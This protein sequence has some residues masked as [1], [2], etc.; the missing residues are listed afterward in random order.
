MLD[1]VFESLEISDINN[2]VQKAEALT[3]AGTGT[4]Y[5]NTDK[6]YGVVH[7]E[8]T[9][10]G[11]FYGVSLDGN[12]N[13]TNGNVLTSTLEWTS[14]SGSSG[15]YAE[16]VFIR[17]RVDY[18]T[19]KSVWLSNNNYFNFQV[20]AYTYSNNNNVQNQK[21]LVRYFNT[22]GTQIGSDLTAE[23]TSGNYITTST[24]DP[25]QKVG[26]IE[27][28]LYYRGNNNTNIRNPEI[29]VT[30]EYNDTTA[31]TITLAESLGN[32]NNPLT[33]KNTLTIGDNSQLEKASLTYTPQ[34]SSSPTVSGQETSYSNTSSTMTLTQGNY[35]KYTVTVTDIFGLSTSK[36]FYYISKYN[37]ETTSTV[38]SL[39][40]MFGADDFNGSAEYSVPMAVSDVSVL[41]KVSDNK[42]YMYNTLSFT[43]N[44][45]SFGPVLSSDS[46]SGHA[47]VY[48]DI[49]LGEYVEKLVS[50]GVQIEVYFTGTSGSGISH[51]FGVF[52][53]ASSFTTTAA[54]SL[55]CMARWC[56]DYSSGN[57]S[58]WSDSNIESGVTAHYG[59]Q[60][61]SMT[62]GD[63]SVPR[64]DLYLSGRY[65]RIILGVYSSS[66]FRA[67]T[68]SSPTLK[69]KISDQVAPEIS[70]SAVSGYSEWTTSPSFT[71]DDNGTDGIYSYSYTFADFAGA[72]GQ[73]ASNTYSINDTWATS[74]P[75]SFPQMGIYT[76][77]A[78]DFLGNATEKTVKYWAPTLNLSIA[79][80]GAT[81]TTTGGTISTGSV[82]DATGTNYATSD[83]SNSYAI[84]DAMA[85][86]A[87]PNAGY[88]YA[89]L[90]KAS[91]TDSPSEIYGSTLNRSITAVASTSLESATDSNYSG[92]ISTSN[93]EFLYTIWLYK[94]P[95]ID[96]G[97]GKIN[98]VVNFKSINASFATSET[99]VLYNNISYPIT[100]N[101]TSYTH[102]DTSLEIYTAQGIYNGTLAGSNN[103]TT[104][105]PKNAGTYTYYGAITSGNIVLGKT[106]TQSLTIT[107]RPITLIAD[108]QTQVYGDTH[109]AL[110][111]TVSG[112]YAQNE[113]INILNF[114]I[115]KAEPEKY[116]AGS[117]A[118][119]ITAHND[120]YDI[121]I[122]NATYTISV[123]EMTLSADDKEI[124]YG[125]DEKT[126]TYS[127]ISGS[128]ASDADK[129]NIGVV[130][131]RE[132]GTV[133]NEYEITLSYA[134]DLDGNYRLTLSNE[135]KAK[136]TIK[137]R[138]ITFVAYDQTQVYGDTQKN[139]TY[140]VSGL[141]SG[142]YAPGED[143]NILNFSIAKS[144]PDIYDAGSYDIIITATNDN[145]DIT[146]TNAIYRIDQ[147]PILLTLTANS[148]S[149]T[150]GEPD[151]T[152]GYEVEYIGD[153]G[154]IAIV[155]ASDLTINVVRETGENVGEYT[156][157]IECV[158]KDNRE[159]Y[160][161]ETQDAKLI[162]NK[163]TLIGV[164]IG[165]NSPNTM[166]LPYTGTEFTLL[167]GYIGFAD[168]EDESVISGASSISVT[169]V[170]AGYTYPNAGKYTASYN[171]DTAT[172]SN[173]DI[174]AGNDVE[175]EITK[176]SLTIAYKEE[177]ITFGET[178]K[179]ELKYDGFVNGENTDVL[180]KP[181]S[182]SFENEKNSLGFV[183][184]GEYTITPSG[185]SA[186][187]YD[188]AYVS[189]TLTV[190]KKAITA[191]YTNVNTITYGDTIAVTMADITPSGLVS[192][193][194]KNSL[195]IASY[196][197][198]A[199]TNAGTHEIDSSNIT[200]TANNYTVTVSGSVTI[201]K[202]TL[203]IGVSFDKD[204][205]TYGE[206][207]VVSVVYKG[208]K[209]T[210]NE[211][212]V[213]G[214]NKPTA[215]LTLNEF[216]LVNAGTH[217]I[218]PSVVDGLELQ[219]YNYS[220]KSS[221][222]TI[223]KAT[224]TIT[225]LGEEVVYDGKPQKPS[226][227]KVEVVGFVA[228]D[229]INLG[230]FTFSHDGYST[231]NA[232]PSVNVI[233]TNDQVALLKNYSYTQH[234]GRFAVIPRPITFTA[235]DKTQVY[236]NDQTE[237]TYQVGGL[238]YAD[239]EDATTLGVTVQKADGND[240]G[241][242][243]ITV[244][245]TNSNYEVT[246]EKGTYTITA[247]PIE[248]SFSVNASK[249]YD[250]QTDVTDE[251]N[252][253][254]TNLVAGD[255][256]AL[257]GISAS[258]ENKDVGARTVTILDGFTLAGDDAANYTL[259]GGAINKD[260]LSITITKATLTVT[261]TFD[262]VSITEGDTVTAEQFEITYA[263]FVNGET[264]S[265]LTTK[266]SVDLIAVSNL[267]A[268]KPQIP[269]VGATATN[270]EF[271]YVV[272]TIEVK[273]ARTLIDASGLSFT[274]RDLT[275]NGLSQEITIVWEDMPSFVQVAYVYKN[276]LGSVVSEQKNVGT[277][278]VT[279]KFTVADA[280]YYM[281]PASYEAQMVIG[282]KAVSV[283][284]DS[285]NLSKIYDGNRDIT[286]AHEPE[287]VGLVDGE[288][289]SYNLAAT[290]DDANVGEAKKIT[291]VS[292]SATAG[293]NT[294]FENY[295]ITI[296]NAAT[297]SAD[298]TPKAVSVTFDS[299]NLS[300]VYDGNRDITLAREP[301]I[302]GLV[303]GES[304]SYN[305]AA[306]FDDAN[307]GEAKKI[308]LVSTSATADANTL[309]EN[310]DITITNADA[311]TA[312]VIARP[313]D[314]T[315]TVNTTKTYDGTTTLPE[316]HIAGVAFD[317][318]VDGEELTY[319]I[320]GEFAI[321]N[322]TLN[323]E[324]VTLTVTKAI[325]GTTASNYYF[326]D[327]GIDTCDGTITRKV[328]S[329]VLENQTSVYGEPVVVSND[330]W[331]EAVVDSIVEGDKL[332][333]T[334]SRDGTS[335][336][337]N[338]YPLRATY[339]N[340]NYSVTFTQA[341]Y[342][343]TQAET[344]VYFDKTN[345][346]FEYTGEKVAINSQNFYV[347][348]NRDN[349]TLGIVYPDMAKDT[350][351]GDVEIKNVG[352]YTLL[353]KVVNDT[354]DSIPDNFKETEAKLVVRVVK[355]K[356][357]FDFS[358]IAQTI[359]RY[360]GEEQHI[361][362]VTSTNTD[363]GAVINYSGNTFT[364]VPENGEIT[365]TV[366][367]SET[368]NYYAS[369]AT[370]TVFVLKANYDL[371]GYTFENETYDYDG[372]MHSVEVLGL[373]E[374]ISVT[375]T[376][377]DIVSSEPIEIKDAGIYIVYADYTYDE[378]NYEMP[379]LLKSAR[380]QINQISITV[381]VT[382]QEGYYGE[383]P[384]FD[385]TGVNVIAGNFIPGDPI[386]LELKLEPRDSYPI[387][388]YQ[389]V[390]NTTSSG[391]YNVTVAT[392]TY[393]I[394]PRPIVL[395][396]DNRGSEYGEEDAELAWSIDETSPYSIIEGD[397][398]NAA[399]M[400]AEGRTPGTYAISGTI[401]NP[402][403]AVTL[404]EGEYTITPRKI[405]I[406]LYNQEGTDPSHLNK[407]GY[408]V[409]GGIL[410]GDDLDIKVVAD[411]EI[412]STPGNYP[413]TA[414]YSDNPNYE[415]KVTEAVFTLRLA[416]KIS[417]KNLIYSKLYDGVPYVFDA[418]VSSGA[419][420]IFT[421]NG[422]YVDNAFTEVG[423]YEI[424]IIAPIT[425]DY[426]EPEQYS[427]TF[428]IRPTELIAEQSGITFMLSKEDG[429][430]ADETLEVH[431][432]QEIVLSGENYTQEIDSAYS[433]YIIR[434][435]ERIPLEE[436]AR[437]QKVN[438]RIKLSD[439]LQSLGV[440]TW[441]VDSEENVLYSVDEHKEG[442]VEVDL[443]GGSMHVLFVAERDEAMPLL[444]VGSA[445]GLA[446]VI[447]FFFYLFRKK[448]L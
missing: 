34:G 320:K 133:A 35:G 356:P 278:N 182:V 323:G 201:S 122:T 265:V 157:S 177:T 52:S 106:A 25:S 94:Q 232:A 247:R 395:R 64:K 211:N 69:L 89:G 189:G 272:G 45:W 409:S 138:P 401:V 267:A 310:Y 65:M 263:G 51:T 366:Y 383:E 329:I 302:V 153:S 73:G 100:F 87:K 347:Y 229:N 206:V 167:I 208:F 349:P 192:G 55:Y 125:D 437:G 179:G 393:T 163:G 354:T 29:I 262:G 149:K 230:E 68:M 388:T 370:Y 410:R 203:S 303:D 123:R 441:F 379:V 24:Y 161:V 294:L 418:S 37:Q 430:G 257:S 176:A 445:M 446:F 209:Y 336:N 368:E 75:L 140:E 172:A 26:Y 332:G 333:I 12:T 171:I 61:Q 148:Y 124:Y 165:L 440:S 377:N 264:D 58:N 367:I 131:T 351:G 341:N 1:S 408:K 381:E 259:D 222:I 46:G 423:I 255:D 283:T 276:A 334:I 420:P 137:K 120:N 139:L 115:A 414:T 312:D 365:I 389:L 63:Y 386:D 279:A 38:V 394:L 160:Y 107:Q 374:S 14:S 378:R 337:A 313:I 253:T 355:A 352:E 6:G 360:N 220:V 328:I 169:A 288:S 277:Y 426:A 236:G 86:W 36:T 447:L 224:L 170:N 117:Y 273:A 210:D 391:N 150:Y 308:A 221:S 325:S 284:F 380:L 289:I 231:V 234:T 119:I 338:S 114:S 128:F 327:G 316:S 442:V 152:F 324:T 248:I 30:S 101:Q 134:S 76:I 343:I 132:E 162:I 23:A 228:K 186:V 218:T 116:D 151:P 146:I 266:A 281:E 244:T 175:F 95:T 50:N 286:L 159:N 402:N 270:Y 293:A 429:F 207:P 353:F 335:L 84:G 31:P 432:T 57:E 66:S 385:P 185:A 372:T 307:V 318:K 164:F 425:G 345:V 359:Y 421:I 7:T 33:T 296:T 43:D 168:G 448:A 398:F 98:L 298:I 382:H 357:T 88:Y 103:T 56:T 154:K 191:T 280:N 193:D 417:V 80:D 225:Y 104:A 271:N 10:T 41:G 405:T 82:S 240:V 141:E 301:Q 254:F 217:T 233:L 27:V 32:Y 156:I 290:F 20:R 5:G 274:S 434:D 344:E 28:F 184:S 415:V 72:S 216:E 2:N 300:K 249:V 433:I 11:T 78:R 83:I 195:S 435:D 314:L 59:A 250:G 40:D 127:I 135:G 304:I 70:Y 18:T 412:G 339:T 362:G 3:N 188:I 404:I 227:D 226:S 282:T 48:Y 110:T 96:I 424:T 53:K 315:Y 145:Y 9:G 243:D 44:A 118:I 406:V 348:T 416:A 219:N 187:N 252:Y 60:G 428:E 363:S 399:L 358:A 109:K 62:Y 121:T 346:E 384:E 242:Y 111:Y 439:E 241:D 200:I 190:N 67:A 39:A 136:Y 287:I 197:L 126:L 387:G 112:T 309:I 144:D 256:L 239:G 261:I 143:I 422:I 413:L 147:R 340:L 364:D 305:L 246:A 299:T 81:G 297:L 260:G 93:I 173:Y 361:T 113:D 375:Y 436:Y 199:Y 400:R 54:S 212:S 90:T 22:S 215:E 4:Q 42:L 130:L 198:S 427:F 223:Q 275:Y 21:I 419:T 8:I 155:D 183:A 237:L 443:E 79:T 105:V 142:I 178:P 321:K 235:D 311:L 204:S 396:A 97:D 213:F 19:N 397:V 77:S 407:K 245:A 91:S 369:S 102:A 13:N 99:E 196:N 180:A 330:K 285:T 158:E 74:V 49:D 295:D 47:V 92:Y 438:L 444:I 326:V 85:F 431:Q 181:A 71:I 268:G 342:V 202:A 16:R 371:S 411:G 350:L 17:I 331:S 194:S 322:A 251:V 129:T 403:Y 174:K 166:S 373:P 238:G 319:T 214:E 306:T 376:C 292:T 205:Y 317:N 258:V 291:L 392:G 269:Y 108:N 390:A 15:S